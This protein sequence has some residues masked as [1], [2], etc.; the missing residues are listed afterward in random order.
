MAPDGGGDDEDDER[1][2]EDGGNDGYRNHDTGGNRV[3]GGGNRDDGDSDR[4]QP[5]RPPRPT[6]PNLPAAPHNPTEFNSDDALESMDWWDAL[7]P[8]QQ[9]RMTR[10]FVIQTPVAATPTAA[11]PTLAPVVIQL[12]QNK[13]KKRNFEY[14]RGTTTESIEAWLATV[15]QAPPGERVDS[16]ANSLANIGFGKRVSTEA[17]LE[18]FFD[19]L[20]NHE[21]AAHIRTMGSQMLSEAVEFTIN[22]YGDTRAGS[23]AVPRY[24]DE[25]KAAGRLANTTGLKDGAHPLAALHAIVVA[26]GIGQAAAARVPATKG[27]AAKPRT[28]C[29]LEVKAETRP[30]GAAEQ[31]AY[32]Q[33]L[34]APPHEGS[35]QHDSGSYKD[36]QIKGKTASEETVAHSRSESDIQTDA[37]DGNDE[38][39]KSSGAT[40]T[41]GENKE[42][43]SGVNLRKRQ[44]LGKRLRSAATC[45]AVTAVASDEIGSD[46][47]SSLNPLQK[48][49][50]NVKAS[51]PTQ[52]VTAVIRAKDDGSQC[53]RLAR[54]V[55]DS[56]PKVDA[57]E[58]SI[59]HEECSGYLC[60]SA[61][62][63]LLHDVDDNDEQKVL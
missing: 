29:T 25:G 2:D 33:T 44:V 53:D 13:V 18:A 45:T 56:T 37:G 50:V 63:E 3:N 57:A 58:E 59:A 15:Q 36:G 48:A 35:R 23:D 51:T 32:L 43:N 17:Y 5:R 55:A 16:F 1:S 24:D 14:F 4:D 62:D 31:P 42:K 47:A 61:E 30:T 21:A 19:G 10:R 7:T 6:R 12:R 41:D 49:R 40:V 20:N 52:A 28:A 46:V 60:Q 38:E 8:G 9:R 22:G 54:I 11:S 34:T 27:E 39:E 26:T